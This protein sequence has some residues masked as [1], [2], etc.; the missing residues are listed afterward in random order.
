MHSIGERD[1]AVHV[2]K[3]RNVVAEGCFGDVN[4][5]IFIVVSDCNSHAACSSPAWFERNLRVDPHLFE[6]TIFQV[7]IEKTRSEAATRPEIGV[8]VVVEIGGECSKSVASGCLPD[9]SLG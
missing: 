3:M 6:R 9:A 7:V 4:L 8:S 2:I 1:V 5:T